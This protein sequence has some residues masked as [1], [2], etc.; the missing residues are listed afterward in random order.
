LIGA[1]ASPTAFRS[2]GKTVANMTGTTGNKD[3]SGTTVDNQPVWTK[4]D[5]TTWIFNKTKNKYEQVRFE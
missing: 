1:V 2:T 3:S 5:G 4:A